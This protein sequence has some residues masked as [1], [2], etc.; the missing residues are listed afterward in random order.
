MASS[1]QSAFDIAF[2]S[3]IST[4]HLGVNGSQADF[5]RNDAYFRSNK[6]NMKYEDFCYNSLPLK[7]EENEN[8]H[9]KKVLVS[10]KTLKTQDSLSDLF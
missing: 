7:I 2:P 4:Y 8:S 1:S 3:Q 9:K 6:E 5:V 10:K